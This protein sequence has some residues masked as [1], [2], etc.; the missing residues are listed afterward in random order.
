MKA[1]T[2]AGEYE[3]RR[4]TILHEAQM[5]QQAERAVNEVNYAGEAYRNLAAVR[6]NSAS[7][8]ENLS[9]IT[10][11][12]VEFVREQYAQRELFERRFQQIGDE[13]HAMKDDDAKTEYL[14]LLL[15]SRRVVILA[16][17]RSMARLGAYFEGL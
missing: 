3:H 7:T 11:M 6:F 10:R 13:I 16:W 15:Q 17:Q 12:T 8:H 1:A 9:E 5:V 2:P 14:P 4:D